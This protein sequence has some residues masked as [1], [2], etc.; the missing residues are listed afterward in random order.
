MANTRL[1][2]DGMILFIEMRYRL[3][4]IHEN[5]CP[6]HDANDCETCRLIN[7]AANY[8]LKVKAEGK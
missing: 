7:H 2:D 1:D 8:A 3:K 6:K 5:T 4:R